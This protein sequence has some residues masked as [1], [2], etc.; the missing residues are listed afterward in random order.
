MWARRGAAHADAVD[1]GLVGDV[2]HVLAVAQVR[3]R[4]VDVGRRRA[5]AQHD[6]RA[7]VAADRVLARKTTA[8]KCAAAASRRGCAAVSG[9]G[10]SGIGLSG[11]GLSGIGCKQDR[12][13]AGSA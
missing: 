8:G 10:L 12:L 3:E 13:Q 7:R 11:I 9:I 4:V 2:Q 5:H 6:G 1:D